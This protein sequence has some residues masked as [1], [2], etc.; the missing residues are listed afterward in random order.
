MA[1]GGSPFEVPPNSCNLVPVKEAPPHPH[2]ARIWPIWPG[3]RKLAF[4]RFA[5]E[6]VPA[7]CRGITT[8]VHMG[9]AKP[10]RPL[11]PKTEDLVETPRPATDFRR[12][13][14]FIWDIANLLRGSDLRTSTPGVV[15]I[16]SSEHA[17]WSRSHCSG[18]SEMPK[19]SAA[20]YSRA[21]QNRFRPFSKCLQIIQQLSSLGEPAM[22]GTILRFVL[23]LQ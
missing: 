7:R 4:G 2:S 5:F 15:I 1:A 22:P 14:D 8:H 6:K 17:L 19:N 10:D 18:S 16:I 20:S 21:V 13:S 3:K 9:R 11:F 23:L 12:L